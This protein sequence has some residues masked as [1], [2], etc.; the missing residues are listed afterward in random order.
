MEHLRNELNRIINGG[1]FRINQHPEEIQKLQPHSI[2]LV[3]DVLF[4]YPYNCFAF[5]FNVVE[6]EPIIR[7]LK[8]DAF[9][10]GR[11]DVKFG[12]DFVKKLISENFLTKDKDG[13]IIIYFNE[14]LPLH[15][16]KINNDRV[17]SK[18]G[19]GLLW[20][21]GVWE[22]PTSYGNDYERFT[23]TSEEDIERSF[24]DYYQSLQ[25]I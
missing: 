25:N 11:Y 14:D 22:V 4:S 8:E 24:E 10:G 5:A 13:D 12:P 1:V 7:I 3:E 6:S 9:N 16:G 21:H 18:W 15:G 20:N 2:N 23:L 17:V 19:V